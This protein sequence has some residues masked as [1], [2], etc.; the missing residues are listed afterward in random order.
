MFTKEKVIV[1]YT[2][3]KYNTGIALGIV[4]R[5]PNILILITRPFRYFRFILIERHEK[6]FMMRPIGLIINLYK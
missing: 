6:R 5:G 2:F 4:L 1:Q 3:S